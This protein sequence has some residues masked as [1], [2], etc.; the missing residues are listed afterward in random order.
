[1]TLKSDA[2]FEEKVTLHSKN[3]MRN[4]V[5][6]HPTTQKSK[7]FT[8]MS[9]FCPKHMRFELKN[10]EVM[11]NLSKPWP[12]DFK[13]GVINWVSFHYS[14]QSLKNCTLMGSFCPKYIMFQLKNFREIMCHD[15]EGYA[16]F[17]GKLSCGFKNNLRNLL[18]IHASSW[19]FGNL[20]FD[21]ILLSKA[22]KNSDE[23]VQKSYVPWHWRVMQSLKKN[24]LSVPK[25]T[26]EI[27]WIFIQPLKSQKISLRWASF[28]QSTWGL[29]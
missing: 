4:L 9:Q 11:Q 10:T 12:C 5:N 7:N 18:N 29:S 22:Y 21:G 13:N 15:T 23:K 28:V 20:H 3:G 14:T 1:M 27:W 6:F 16:N 19:K 8:S 2:K 17:K 25:M 26:W 24:W